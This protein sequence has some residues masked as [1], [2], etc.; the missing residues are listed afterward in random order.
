MS[1]KYNNHIIKSITIRQPNASLIVNGVINTENRKWKKRLSD[2]VCKNW[3]FVH[4][5]KKVLQSSDSTK[6]VLQ[7]SII[8]MMHI[9]SIISHKDSVYN[10]KWEKGPYCWYID[11]VIPFKNPIS[12]TG[13][14]GQWNPNERVFNLLK[15]QIDKSVCNIITHDGINFKK[16]D[17]I[18]YA[19]QRGKYMSWSQVIESL[20]SKEY[21]DTF[22]YKLIYELINIPYKAYFWEC[23]QVNMKKPFRFAVYESKTLSKRIQDNNAFDGKID[24]Y[25]NVIK[26]PSLSKD[27]NLIS[28]CNK[29][30]NSNYTSLATF[31]R[32]APL[33]QQI[34]FW[35][36][37]GNSIKEDDWISTSGLGVSWL[38]LRI[39]KY[40]T[41]YHDDFKHT[42]SDR[43]K[44]DNMIDN[45]HFDKGPIVVI[46]ENKKWSDNDLVTYYLELLPTDT[47]I[48]LMGNSGLFIKKIKEF[49]FIY[50]I[51]S[52]DWNKGANAGIK[53]NT[54]VLL[55]KVSLVSVF[56]NQSNVCKDLVKQST[57]LKIPILEITLGLK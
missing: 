16:E 27:M 31:S 3:L 8:G 13:S 44:I 6:K 55:K 26:F 47:R 34:S 10:G 43:K 19:V 35:V 25:K 45:F 18:Y 51:S 23:D 17:N 39:E 46:Y 4:S 14:L 1:F 52:I 29:N 30:K 57:N 32:T 50:K 49:G 12:A 11:A 24:C 7:S 54:E 22:K 20:K 48:I 56:G 37:V 9:H 15:E 40:P 28:P 36:K 53:N 42:K 21:T 33:K 41:Y 5:S 38:H 2:N